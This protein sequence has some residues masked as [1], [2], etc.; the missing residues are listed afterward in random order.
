MLWIAGHGI[1]AI[2]FVTG[3]AMLRV[4]GQ[5]GNLSRPDLGCFEDHVAAM[6]ELE[7]GGCG[8]VHADF[9]RPPGAAT[10]GDDRLRVAGTA[11]L[12]EV[13]DDRCMLEAMDQAVCDITDEANVEPLHREL[14]AAAR[15]G[16]SDWYN[17][18]A[19]LELA[20]AML[21]A[22]DAADQSCPVVI[23]Q[24]HPRQRSMP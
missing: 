9:L 10:H 6:F 16:G 7:G 19:S 12:L 11:G 21:A 24:R 23:A 3:Q 1:D 22:R 14:L 17:T 20:A 4:Y 8:I 15:Q 5:G 2:R 18:T 13:R